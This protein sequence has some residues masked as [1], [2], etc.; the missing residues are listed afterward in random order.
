MSGHQ[1]E[2]RG[3]RGQRLL[4][5]GGTGYIGG[6]LVDAALE[7]GLRVR[8]LVRD[9]SAQ[10]WGERVEVHRG[11][12]CDPRT[13]AGVEEDV[14][15]V[16]HAAAVLGKWG[17]PES[18][19]HAVNVEGS[20][21]LLERFEGRDRV[22]YLHLSAGG[23]AGPSRETLLDEEYECRPAT[24]YERTKLQAEREVLARAP[25]LGV[26]AV[27]LRPTFTYGPGDPHKLALY[28]AVARGRFVFIG[29]GESVVTPVYVED[30]IRGIFLAFERAEPGR[31]YLI[32]GERP[33]T[34]KELIGAIAGALGVRA[35][36]IHVP[37]WFASACAACLEPLGRGL[38]FEPVLTRSR[39]MMM[40]DSFG[41][42]IA[43][44]RA[45]LGYE[46]RVALDEGVARTVAD[47]RARGWL[48]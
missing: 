35:P 11:D 15:L 12:L 3:E 48:G 13:L 4:V 20:L 22:G 47:Y 2:Q 1:G 6:R 45:E 10:R 25:A 36:R 37:R 33:V 5:T 29:D 31:I 44:A 21:A 14:D 28:R 32:G 24:A 18:T 19:I 41:Y 26:P 23:V 34:K 7:R 8:V 38:G 16:V 27:V 46:P 39:V 17:Q 9:P 43:R 40:G 42:A 30:L